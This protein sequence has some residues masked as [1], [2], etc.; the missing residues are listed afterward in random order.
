MDSGDNRQTSLSSPCPRTEFIRPHVWSGARP[1]RSANV[2]NVGER[3]GYLT[4]DCGWPRITLVSVH[5]VHNS[6]PA[7]STGA[8]DHRAAFHSRPPPVHTAVHRVIHRRGAS[9]RQASITFRAHPR[10]S[11]GNPRY[12]HLLSTR[13]RSYP[14]TYPPLSWTHEWSRQ[15]SGRFKRGSSARHM[16]GKLSTLAATFPHE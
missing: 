5:S 7:H 1:E 10:P 3:S 11:T 6:S 14:Q 12:S 16:G 15:G 8:V 4:S 9:L 2:G 13:E